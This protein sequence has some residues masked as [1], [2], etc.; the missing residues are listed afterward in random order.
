MKINPETNAPY[1]TPLN[2]TDRF[3]IRLT[4]IEKLGIRKLAA[5][6][7]QTMSK[8]VLKIM[9][10]YFENAV[11]RN[12]WNDVYKYNPDFDEKQSQYQ[13]GRTKR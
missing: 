13:F 6:D 8:A 9:K 1:N 2:A 5:L 12:F 7:K 3:N 4:P 10:F 11:P